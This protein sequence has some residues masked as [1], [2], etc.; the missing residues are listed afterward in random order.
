MSSKNFGKIPKMAVCYENDRI[1][2]WKSN[3]EYYLN[4]L[5][6]AGGIYTNINDYSKYLEALRQRRIFTDSTHVLLFK[7]MSMKIEFHSHHMSVLKGKKSSYA[8]GWEITDSLAVS[9]GLYYGVNNRV[10]L[11]EKT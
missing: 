10:E 4:H 7:S 8:M 11:R 5:I 2:N 9:A 1:G 3:E 6:E